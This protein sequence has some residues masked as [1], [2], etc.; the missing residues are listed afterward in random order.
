M[1]AGKFILVFLIIALALPAAAQKGKSKSQL[2]KEKQKNLEKIKETE[3]ILNETSKQKKNSLGELSALTQRITQQEQ[4]IGSIKGEISL[5]DRDID[6]DNDMIDALEKDVSDLK[7]EYARMV[8]SAQKANNKIDQL[9]FIFSSKSF[10]QLAMR[11]KYMQQY[12]KTRKAQAEA[13]ARTQKI[14]TSQI[15]QTET[16]K[17]AKNMLLGDQVKENQN[18]AELKTKQKSVVKSLQ[19]EERRLREDIE[20]TKKAVAELDRMIEEIIREEIARAEREAREA[21]AKSAADA[22]RVAKVA[23]SNVALSASFEENRHKF[24]WPT[25]GFVSSR[26]GVQPHPTLKGVKLDNK[27]IN[28]QT[29]QHEKVKV[30][31]DGEV[32]QVGSMGVIGN[33]VMIIHGGYYTVYA[34]LKDVA[35]KR[36]DKVSA[37]QEIG[38]LMVNGDG[39]SELRFMIYKSAGSGAT[40]LDPQQWLKN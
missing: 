6:E 26:F 10:D 16:V 3:R 5:L 24:A 20:D 11:L 2:Q 31:F 14:L 29:P 36:G 1:S 15:Q 35:V 32:R 7:K 40:P 8:F 27:G 23:E 39:V 25:S 28:I 17:K 33:Y 34:G 22:A 38:Q 30:I 18:L 12:G 21:K 19:K 9:T 4:L 13:I 37:N